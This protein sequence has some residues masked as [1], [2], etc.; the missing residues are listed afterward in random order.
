MLHKFS[1]YLLNNTHTHMRSDM[2]YT[3]VSL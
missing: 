1:I 2:A 3:W